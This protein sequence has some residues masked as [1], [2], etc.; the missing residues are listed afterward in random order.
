MDSY[1]VKGWTTDIVKDIS[2]V[3]IDC[4]H[5]FEAVNIDIENALK[6]NPDYIIFDDYGLST[7][8]EVKQAVDNHD[9]I[10]IVKRIGL[11]PG[12][13]EAKD[14]PKPMKFVDSEG[15]ICKVK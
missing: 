14:R 6:L 11:E 3:M 2:V 8:A 1:S 7:M 5:T 9:K 15:V 10:E 13:Y 4:V 12:E